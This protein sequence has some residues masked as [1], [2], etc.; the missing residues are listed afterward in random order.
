MVAV[1][2]AGA[3]TQVLTLTLTLTLTLRWRLGR[4]V[5]GRM[6]G[7]RKEGLALQGGR[8]GMQE[9]DTQN[10]PPFFLFFGLQ[11]VNNCK[12]NDRLRCRPG[13]DREIGSEIIMGTGCFG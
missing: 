11:Q 13:Y 3:R 4:C 9:D 7:G 2:D 12:T 10:G 6:G 1:D 5:R 8:Y